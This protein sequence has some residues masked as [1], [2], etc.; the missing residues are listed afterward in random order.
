MAEAQ[1]YKNHTRFDP[2]FHF[3]LLPIFLLNIVAASVWCYHHYNVHPHIAPW[4]IVVAVALFVL[5]GLMRSYSLKVQDRVIRLEERLRLAAL[6]SPAEMAELDSLTLKQY[7]ALRFASNPEVSELARR[8]IREKM[9]PKMIKQ[10]IVSWRAD[11][12]RV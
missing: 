8:A 7:V 12:D 11:H 4:A 10:A 2:P 9:E 5:T 6:C 3:F 1:S